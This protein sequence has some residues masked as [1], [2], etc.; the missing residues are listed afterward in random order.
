MEEITQ[1]NPKDILF[2]QIRSLCAEKITP[3]WID[4]IKTTKGNTQSS[5]RVVIQKIKEVLDE[6]KL[7]YEEAGSQQSKDFRNVGGIGLDIEIKKTLS[8][9]TLLHQAGIQLNG[10]QVI[11]QIHPDG[12]AVRF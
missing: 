6:L 11:Q 3:D 5:E 12:N 4:T 7:T 10:D 8:E 2:S 9:N 1:E